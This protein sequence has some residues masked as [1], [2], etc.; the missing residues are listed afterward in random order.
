MVNPLDNRGHPGAV[1]VPL[2]GRS[3]GRLIDQAQSE[4]LTVHQV[5]SRLLTA[6]LNEKIDE[7]ERLRGLMREGH[8]FDLPF[9]RANACEWNSSG[10][11]T[12]EGH[13]GHVERLLNGEA[14]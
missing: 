3:L 6:A 7:L 4:G 12:A 14:S 1:D 13:A 9:C 11:G 8:V 5:A 10:S 2:D